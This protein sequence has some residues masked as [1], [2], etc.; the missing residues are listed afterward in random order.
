MSI[1]Y[2]SNQQQLQAWLSSTAGQYLQAKEQVLYDQ[3]VV[4]LFGFNAL[5][6]GCAQMNLL[7]NSRIP[8]RFVAS[9]FA[10]DTANYQLSCS[11]DF[12]P[13]ADMSIDLL[14]LPHRLEFSER[15]HQTLREAARVMMPDGHLVIS[16]FN[17]LSLWG[18][19]AGFKKKVSNQL[20]YPWNGKF[21]GLT[22]LK[23]WLA[24]LGF[25]VVSVEMCCHIPPFEQPS[26][27]KRFSF[28]DKISSRRCAMLGGVYFIVAKK[29]VV[30]M[31]PIKPNWKRSP[32]KSTLIPSPTQSKPTQK[33][34]LKQSGKEN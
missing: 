12:L 22:R 2:R 24:L 21:I 14:L 16:G 15:P 32:L 1:A 33:N 11:D 4:D 25:E 17:R 3:A 26:W 18:V 28:F 13:F 10:T 29:R 27:Q 5:Q 20:S 8:N 9:E 31:M 6:M 34:L 30:G 7:R 23:D 19:T